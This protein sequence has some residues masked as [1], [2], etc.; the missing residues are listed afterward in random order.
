MTTSNTKKIRPSQTSI[1]LSKADFDELR[2]ACP[3]L[4]ALSNTALVQ[5]CFGFVRHRSSAPVVAVPT[6]VVYATPL[7]VPTA[8]VK[9]SVELAENVVDVSKRKPFDFGNDEETY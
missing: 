4:S 8:Q 2:Q 1:G 3:E 7:D 5:Y 6:P 9:Q